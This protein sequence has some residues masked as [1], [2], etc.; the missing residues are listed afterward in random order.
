MIVCTPELILVKSYQAEPIIGNR[1]DTSENIQRKVFTDLPLC[2]YVLM[3]M[4]FIHYM[5][6]LTL[7]LSLRSK[8]TIENWRFCYTTLN[9]YMCTPCFRLYSVWCYYVSC[10]FLVLKLSK[11]VFFHFMCK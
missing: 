7:S 4:T 8:E 2:F 6:F 11:T 1:T 5:I 3:Q 10:L 9:S